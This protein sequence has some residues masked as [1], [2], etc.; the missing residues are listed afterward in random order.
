MFHSKNLKHSFAAVS[1]FTSI[2]KPLKWP[3]PIVP[4]I[5]PKN[6]DLMLSPF[7]ILGCI[8]DDV[9]YVMNKWNSSKEPNLVHIDMDSNFKSASSKIKLEIVFKQHP[10]VDRIKVCLENLRA[11][12][13]QRQTFADDFADR[14]NLYAVELVTMVRQLLNAVYMF[15]D[16]VM[17]ATVDR[18][19]YVANKSKVDGLVLQ[20]L[21]QSQMF[22]SLFD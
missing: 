11:S 6:Y 17:A 12:L 9:I 7:P 8:R 2:L 16:P 13:P 1:F 22:A 20:R 19:L 10:A 15:D 21:L 18:R 14:C 3:Y 4:V 5:I